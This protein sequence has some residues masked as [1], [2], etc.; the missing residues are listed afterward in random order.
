VTGSEARLRQLLETAAGD[1]P[2][3]IRLPDVHRQARQRRMRGAAAFSAAAAVVVIALAATVVPAALRSGSGNAVAAGA[4]G[5]ETAYVATTANEVLVISLRTNAVQK[6]IKIRAAGTVQDMAI[7]PN[8]RTLYVLTAPQPTS[9]VPEPSRAEVTPISTA[10]DRAGIPIRLHGFGQQILIT[11]DSQTAYVLAEGSGLVPIDLSKRQPLREI[12]IHDASAAV[13]KP[14]GKTIYVSS[15]PGIVA[16]DLATGGSLSLIKPPR[17]GSLAYEPV[18]SPDG[19]RLYEPLVGPRWALLAVNTATNTA[20]RPIAAKFFGLQ[21]A[22]GDR[23]RTLYVD[24]IGAVLPIDA[25]TDKP[26]RL[27]RLPSSAG[28]G[29]IASSPDG[30]TVYVTDTQPGVASASWVVPIATATNSAAA[31]IALREPDW[32]PMI[33]AVAADGSVYVGSSRQVHDSAAQTVGL[34]TVIPSGSTTA[35]KI[36]RFGGTPVKI[37][38]AP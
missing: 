23:S 9:A 21:L 22:F 16:V 36:A 15:R 20:L 14:N 38:F 4:M 25:R 18:I 11:P 31:P 5:R 37:V 24:G 3:S 30:R 32:S 28:S 33:M 1:P 7:A 10:T 13:M 19:T 26:Q 17:P 29:T 12:K 27:I 8:G 6:T 34:M 35:R 2:H